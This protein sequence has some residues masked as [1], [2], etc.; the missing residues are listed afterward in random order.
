MTE[1]N[2]YALILTIL[3]VIITLSFVIFTSIRSKQ[4]TEIRKALIEKFGSTEGMVELLRTPEGQRR[5]S[6]LS[7]SG[8]TPVRSVLGSIHKGIIGLVLGL[9][10]LFVGAL[11][12]PAAMPMMILG[13]LFASAGLAFLIAAAITYRLSKAWGLIPKKD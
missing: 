11:A 5:L 6:D 3:L 7:V 8:A 2:G 12:G 10:A 9:G 1:I 4:Q 13:A